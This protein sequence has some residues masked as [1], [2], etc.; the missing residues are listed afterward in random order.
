MHWALLHSFHY[1]GRHNPC[2]GLSIDRPP[3]PLS[4]LTS[5]SF[6]H[7]S[8]ARSFPLTFNDIISEQDQHHRDLAANQSESWRPAEVALV[9]GKDY[10][11]HYGLGDIVADHQ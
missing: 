1:R 9:Y 10:P 2:A 4:Y 11:Q 7:P 8:T 5:S 6:H 3:P